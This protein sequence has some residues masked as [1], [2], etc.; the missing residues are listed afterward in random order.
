MKRLILVLAF[1][2]YALPAFADP[3]CLLLPIV[4]NGFDVKDVKDDDKHGAFRPDIPKQ[5]T[6]LY[7]KLAFTYTTVGFPKITKG[8]PEFSTVVTCFLDSLVIPAGLGPMTRDQAMMVAHSRDSK[9]VFKPDSLKLPDPKTSFELFVD[10]AWR[11]AS[12]YLGA[13]LAFATTATDNFNR[14]DSTDLGAAWDPYDNPS[15]TNCQILFNQVSTATSAVDCVE[16]FSTLIPGANQYVQFSL[17][18][19]FLTDDF[20]FVSAIVRLQAPPTYSGYYC[21]AMPPSQ[22]NTSR[23]RRVDAGSNATLANDTTQTWA[24]ADVLRCEITGTSITFK[25]N[26]TTILTASTSGEY[27]TGRGG[28]NVLDNAIGPRNPIDDFEVGDLGAVTVV[29]HRPLVLQ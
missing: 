24:A 9:I 1:L 22:T 8:V 20:L 18:N 23:I 12:R 16:G 13:A 6:D 3:S 10:R 4:G 29:R 15:A 5:L 26:G 28:I 7:P 2:F 25:R 27:T 11:T 14:A 17:P 21:R 19:G